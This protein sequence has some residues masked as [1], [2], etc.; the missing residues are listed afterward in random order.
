MV[1]KDKVI[2][3]TSSKLPIFLSCA[4][5]GDW[6]MPK[7]DAYEIK[8]LTLDTR[9]EFILSCTVM[10]LSLVILMVSAFALAAPDQ[11]R[12]GP[13]KDQ[14]GYVPLSEGVARCVALAPALA[15]MFFNW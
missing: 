2:S 5:Y 7:C 10:A 12:S 13:S 3:P 11:G 1:M 9:I 15:P 14:V 4:E 8:Q 6:N